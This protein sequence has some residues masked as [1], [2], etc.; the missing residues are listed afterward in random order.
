MPR[1]DLNQTNF[2]SGEITPKC[3][4]RVDISR[5]QNG[6][7]SLENMLVTIHGGAFRRYGSG[8]QAPAKFPDRFCRMIPF[9]FSTT[10]A[11][12]LEFGHQYVRFFNQGGGQIMNGGVPLELATPYTEDMLR[13]MDYTQGADT[14]LL[15][16]PQVYP[17]SLRRLA[18]AT[19]TIGN[20]PFT[21]LPFDEVG[22]RFN[23]TLTISD[24]TPGTGRTLTASGGAFLAGDIGRRITVDGGSALITGI[25][26][27]SIVTG[28][29]TAEFASTAVAANQWVLRDSPQTT[30]TPTNLSPVGNGT[31]LTA[32]TNA[33]R[34]SDVGK[35][36]SLNGGLIRLTVFTD[37]Q[38][39][40]GLIVQVMD[41]AVGAPAGSW[42]LMGQS[43]NQYDG[44]PRTGEFYEQR[45]VLAGSPSYPQTLWGSKTGLF[46][47]F[48]IGT[49]DDDSYAF[50][51]PSTGKINPI[52]RMSAVS[53]L[54]MLTYG[55]EYTASGGVEKPL[56]PTN[57][58]LKPRTRYG[59]NT[60]KPVQI[61]EE[62]FYVTRTGKKVR[63]MSYNYTSDSFPSPNVTTLAEH[64][65]SAGVV[66]MAYQQE[67][68]GRLWCVRADGLLATLTIDRDEGVT[69]WSPQSTDGLYESV[70][71]IP[72]NGI[73]EVWV[74]VQRTIDGA[75]TRY[76]ERFDEAL[77]MDSAILGTDVAGKTA[78]TGLDH[79]EGKMVHA[80]TDGTFAGG[81]TVTDGQI[82]L[83]RAAKSVQ[84]GLP[85][86]GRLIPLRPEIQTGVGSAQ[87]NNM[88]TS[89]VSVLLHNTI[90]GTIN[91]Q[92]LTQRKFGSELL[93]EALA[94][95]SG[96]DHV[97]LSGWERGDSPIVLE[98]AEPLP[99]HVLA[100]IR[101][102]TVNP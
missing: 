34:A 74:S 10:T 2:T 62:L 61:G 69:A 29:V 73:D 95:Y 101:K 94:E 17:Q 11:Y 80:L 32:G 63:A 44:Y 26:S 53:V 33:F 20:A 97:G 98:Q 55:G 37:A 27:A 28:T 40:S 25:T 65:T 100:V 23:L 96:L 5:Y 81:F 1:V 75:V 19:W 14:M 45:L 58:Q 9:V 39:M 8:M 91:D 3:F 82:E 71:S 89:Q 54:L 77:A 43:W 67:P 35:F 93:D 15:F 78:W 84:I 41:S 52:T 16:H 59:C 24:K 36:I 51:L 79:L 7:L 99:F 60:V 48:T 57:P 42:K 88:N 86:T 92:A 49:E 90:G 85:Y 46:F 22:D 76:I 38:H 83:G 6:A 64:I 4:G 68:D 47:D 50:T 30:L 72:N 21:T 70:A 31:A 13:E 66:D 87:G 18:A 12:M 102:F 56:T